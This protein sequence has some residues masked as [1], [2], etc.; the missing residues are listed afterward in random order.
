MTNIHYLLFI[1]PILSILPAQGQTQPSSQVPDPP[2]SQTQTNAPTGVIGFSVLFNG[3][4]WR[5]F[6]GS[7][8]N[9][10]D[11]HRGDRVLGYMGHKFR[12]NRQFQN[13]VVGPVGTPCELTFLH[14][15]RTITVYPKRVDASLFLKHDPLFHKHYHK[16][17][18]KSKTQSQ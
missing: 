7:D 6:P 11:I 16:V 13:D 4:V 15:G 14:D 10:F 5:V 8:L 12:G 18:A 1:L 2:P 9:R 3:K 17:I